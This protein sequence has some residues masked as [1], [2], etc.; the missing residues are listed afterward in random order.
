MAACDDCFEE[1]L[2]PLV[3]AGMEKNEAFKRRFGNFA[4]WNWDDLS[5]TLTLSGPGQPSVRVHCTLVG[6]TQGNQWQWSWANKNIPPNEK[7]DMEKVREFGESHGY[8]TLTVPFLEAD[9]Y[10]G[11][12]MTAVAEHILDA[13]GGYRFPTDHGF[14]YLAYRSVRV[15]GT[16]KDTD[17]RGTT[18]DAVVVAPRVNPN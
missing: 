12:E 4:R 17:L 7:L 11:W 16:D 14:C 1:F 9:E 15:I 10:T 2:D 6:T 8:E 3:H 18:S 5:S 13:L